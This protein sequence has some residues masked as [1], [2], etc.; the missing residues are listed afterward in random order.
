MLPTH[1]GKFPAM[2]HSACCRSPRAVRGPRS[3]KRRAGAGPAHVVFF[4]ADGAVDLGSSTTAKP[5]SSTLRGFAGDGKAL[6]VGGRRGRLTRWTFQVGGNALTPGP[7]EIKELAAGSAIT[8]LVF[9]PSGR[10]AAAS[11]DKV[12]V[13]AEAGPG[14]RYLTLDAPGVRAL[15]FSDDS[16][17][18]AAA[19]RLRRA[20]TSGA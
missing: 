11:R 14:Q 13:A 7:P 6:A 12:H 18:L 3:P 20:W 2:C 4:N 9:S 15:V 19:G 5:R 16:Q 8:A 17:W 1:S 10:L